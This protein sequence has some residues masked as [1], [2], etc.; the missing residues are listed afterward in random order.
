MT[1][2]NPTR[3]QLEGAYRKALSSYSHRDNVTAVDIGYR[4]KDGTRT[5]EL[6]VRVHVREKLPESVLED[7]EL[8]P[9]EIDGIPVDVIQ[10]VYHPHGSDAGEDDPGRRVRVELVRPGVSISH[11]R[12]TAGTLGAIVYDRRTGR[13]GLLSNWHVLVGS[14]DAVPGDPIVQPG[15]ADGGRTPRDTV[16]QLERMILDQDGD[17][18]VALL[19]SARAS[20]SEQWATGVSVTRAR[21]PEIGE[22]LEKSGRTTGVTRARVDGTGR[23][24]LTY[25]VGEV[26]IDGLK[27]VPE[28]PENP[29]DEEVS[30][31]GDSGSLWYGATDRQGVGLHFGGEHDADPRAEHA[32]ACHLERVLDR[33]DLSLVPVVVPEADASAP[34]PTAALPDL[35]GSDTTALIDIVTRLSR[36]LEQ[37]LPPAPPR[38]TSRP[39]RSRKATTRR[40]RSS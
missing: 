33:L 26:A 25:S 38:G 5:D 19:G 29:D 22:I 11:P 20:R 10:A 23:Y 27:L 9:A 7:A 18:A 8:L 2:K 14:D 4:Y 16:G 17:A 13:A 15:R 37:T 40:P 24:K 39:A 28:N 3:R 34:F 32:L 21:G 12:V 35:P 6:A 36:L 30:S 1:G 31:G